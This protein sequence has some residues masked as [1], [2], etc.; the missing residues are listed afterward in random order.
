MAKGDSYTAVLTKT[1]K[2]VADPTVEE[3]IAQLTMMKIWL[4]FMLGDPLDIDLEIEDT[5]D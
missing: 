5:E 3:L 4:P 1:V 2:L